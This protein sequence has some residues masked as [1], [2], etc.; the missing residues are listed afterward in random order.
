MSP[1]L[2]TWHAHYCGPTCL[3]SPACEILK[4]P[5]LTSPP[6]H[7][8]ASSG[9]F[10]PHQT[11]GP[12][13]GPAMIFNPLFHECPPRTMCFHVGSCSTWKAWALSWAAD[14]SLFCTPLQGIHGSGEWAVALW[15]SFNPSPHMGSSEFPFNVST[16][17]LVSKFIWLANFLYFLKN[18]VLSGLPWRISR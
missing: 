17:L 8:P 11:P 14:F 13:T 9:F 7:C 16:S 18:S 12:N 3:L 6:S 2:C 1:L 5:A 4:I 10:T 15:V